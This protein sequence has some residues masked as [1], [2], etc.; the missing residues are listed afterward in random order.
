LKAFAEEV[1]YKSKEY[2]IYT[3]QTSFAFYNLYRVFASL[4]L[5]STPLKFPHFEKNIGIKSDSRS[6][7][8]IN[9]KP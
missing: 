9:H 7:Q 4:V 8:N 5:L 6:S 2:G 3:V 1:Y